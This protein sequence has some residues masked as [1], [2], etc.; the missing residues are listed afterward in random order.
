[1][2]STCHIACV[3]FVPTDGPRSSG[4]NHKSTFY[5]H[6][7]EV[8]N[9]WWCIFVTKFFTDYFCPELTGSADARSIL[10]H[11]LL[12]R[13]LDVGHCCCHAASVLLSTVLTGYS[14]SSQRGW[15][16]YYMMCLVFHSTITGWRLHRLSIVISFT[17]PSELCSTK[18]NIFH[19]GT[20]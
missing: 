2:P 19:S 9:H 7:A 20:N 6:L 15:W 12:C 5:R 10:V 3:L 17:G 13:L 8:L 16:L 1:M 11:T 18:P 4:H 14:V